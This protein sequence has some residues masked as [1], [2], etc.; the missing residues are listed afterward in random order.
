MA[1]GMV[2]P[3]QLLLLFAGIVSLSA[4]IAVASASESEVPHVGP[5]YLAAIIVPELGTSADWYQ[6]HL[7]FQKQETITL[8]NL[9]I[10][11]LV[12]EGFHLEIVEDKRAFT[13]E[14]LEKRIPE[15]K[16][17]DNPV[18]G[19]SKLAFCVTDLDAFATKLKFEGVKFQTGIMEAKGNWPRS[20]IVLDNNGNWIQLV[21]SN[22]DSDRQVRENAR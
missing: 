6:K 19:I 9:R 8:P 4:G 12:L 7:G 5:T 22:T 20:F 18:A 17:L 15:M 1:Y 21:Q 2:G 16:H 14:R 11:F 3:K 13:R 10:T